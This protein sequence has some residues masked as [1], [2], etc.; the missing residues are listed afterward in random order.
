LERNAMSPHGTPKNPYAAQL[1]PETDHAADLESGAPV[2]KSAESQRLNRRALLFLAGIV[3]LL[4]AMAA[5]MV[6]SATADG[7]DKPRPREEAVVIPALPQAPLRTTEAPELAAAEPIPLAPLPQLPPL[8]PRPVHSVPVV[9]PQRDRMPSL[10]ERRAM[11]AGASAEMSAE[12]AQAEYLKAILAAASG[13]PATTDEPAE[14]PASARF[15]HA[16]DALL[17]RGT[18][19]RCVLETR[20]V[21]DIAGFTSCVVTEP[22]YSINGQRLLV[23]KGSKVS[24]RYDSGEPTGPRVA[25]VWDRITTPTG[26]DVA[27]ASPGVDN[28]G[29]AGHPG[30]YDAHWPSRIG[31]A[32]LIS[33]IGDGFK[34]AAAQHGP[35]TTTIANGVVVQEPYESGTARTMERLANRALERNLQRPAT[36]TIQPGEILNI[37]VA[38]DVDF[39]VVLDS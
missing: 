25:V 27:M 30:D 28:L 2:L 12:T 10:A 34:Y 20:I 37:Y 8:P 33:L 7:G 24:G 39:S 35:P 1:R 9:Q 21:T 3:L 19:I 16:P 26:I 22:V 38:R 18:Y 11:S 15:I 4:L 6:R 31:S 32:L 14:P 23:P 29:G 17:V 36:V 13:K 5:W